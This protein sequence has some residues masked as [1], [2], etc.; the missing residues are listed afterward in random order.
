MEENIVYIVT[1]DSTD[2]TFEKDDIIWKC[3][4]GPI[5]LDGQIQGNVHPNHWIFNIGKISVIKL[6]TEAIIRNYAV[7]KEGNMCGQA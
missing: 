4:D 7:H 6:Y 1:K 3:N 5:E 2:K